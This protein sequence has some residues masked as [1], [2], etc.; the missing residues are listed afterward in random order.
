MQHGRKLSRERKSTPVHVFEL[1]SRGRAFL[2]NIRHLTM[3]PI[4]MGVMSLPFVNE[5]NP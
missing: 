1:L 5:G 4:Q 3:T 2:R